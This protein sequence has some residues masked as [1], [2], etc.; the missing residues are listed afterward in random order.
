MIP[1]SFAE[2][3]K[4]AGIKPGKKKVINGLEAEYKKS[5]SLKRK[6]LKYE[7]TQ[8]YKTQ[9]NK[10]RE[11]VEKLCKELGLRVPTSSKKVIKFI[12]KTGKKTNTL[13][14]ILVMSAR[15]EAMQKRLKELQKLN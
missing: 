12:E 7:L 8:A 10:E 1:R 5:R 14:G 2:R 11:Q 4:Q 15:I 13:E 3:I 6:K 9:I